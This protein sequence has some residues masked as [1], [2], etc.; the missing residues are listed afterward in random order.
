L[1]PIPGSPFLTGITGLGGGLFTAH[2][3]TSVAV[4]HFLYAG[5]SGSDNVSAF[6][7]DPAAAS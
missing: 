7:I 5:N 4:K 6:A 3:I 1:T 2:R